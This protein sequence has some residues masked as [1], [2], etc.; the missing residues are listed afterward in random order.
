MSRSEDA[1]LASE[2][3][4]ADAQSVACGL[5]RGRLRRDFYSHSDY[6]YKKG[7]V[8]QGLAEVEMGGVKVC[9]ARFMGVPVHT[10][11]GGVRLGHPESACQVAVV[12]MHMAEH[13]GPRF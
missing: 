8:R 7:A 5:A 12:H 9:Q 3:P 4:N 2:T 6:L 10:A 1:I 11:L 13:P